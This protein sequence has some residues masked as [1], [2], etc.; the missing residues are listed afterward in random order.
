MGLRLGHRNGVVVKA[1]LEQVE[2]QR[3]PAF[4]LPVGGVGEVE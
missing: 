2:F 1:L 4:E 3:Q